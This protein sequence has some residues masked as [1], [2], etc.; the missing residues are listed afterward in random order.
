MVTTVP[1]LYLGSTAQEGAR[2]H[3]RGLL[4][5]DP[6]GHIDFRELAPE[7]EAQIG[8]DEVRDALLWSRYGPVQAGRKVVML[9]PA[10]RL[11][12]EATS[13]LLKSLE[14]APY[15]LAFL[16]HAG[17]P[18]HLPDTIRSRCV[19]RWTLPAWS[20]KLER[21]GLR[22]EERA[23]VEELLDCRADGV[24]ELVEQETRPLDM[25]RAHYSELA[26]SSTEQLTRQWRQAEAD[27]LRR[28]AVVWAVA[29][30]LSE[31]PADE[32]LQLAKELADGG[33]TSCRSFLHHLLWYVRRHAGE[34]C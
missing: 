3:A 6:D 32:V 28:R 20:G 23:L 5:A 4:A 8:I 18:E 25:W 11:S 29:D 19:A 1:H 30:R 17:G 24:A 2:E 14:E 7:A 31:A 16:L 10:E 13:A 12:R 26:A 22:G 33:R 27:P 34:S 21:A 15:Y 9:G